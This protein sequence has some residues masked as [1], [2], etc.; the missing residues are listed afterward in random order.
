LTSQYTSTP[1]KAKS[2]VGE[3]LRS[4]FKRSPKFIVMEGHDYDPA[5][6]RGWQMNV[7]EMS[8]PNGVALCMGAA[9]RTEHKDKLDYVMAGR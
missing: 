1:A 7:T 8:L 4:R 5:S 3:W 6:Q 9:L 2:I